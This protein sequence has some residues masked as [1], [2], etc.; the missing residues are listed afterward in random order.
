MLQYDGVVHKSDT[1]L[2]CVLKSKGETLQKSG[3][4]VSSALWKKTA[5]V[6]EPEGWVFPAT[7]YSESTG[8]LFPRIPDLKS[9]VHRTNGSTLNLF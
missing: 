1:V 3:V 4:Q 6:D 5:I 8:S 7:E 9:I 2:C